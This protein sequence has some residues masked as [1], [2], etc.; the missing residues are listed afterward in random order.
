M[1]SLEIEIPT[2]AIGMLPIDHEQERIRDFSQALKRLQVIRPAEID[3]DFTDERPVP[4]AIKRFLAFEH[5]DTLT[6]YTNPDVLEVPVDRVRFSPR[7]SRVGKQSRHGVFFGDLQLGPG[8]QVPVA[9]KPHLD[10]ERDSCLDEYFNT[11][12]ITQLGMST[13]VELGFIYGD[14]EEDPAYSITVLQEGLSTLDSVDWSS[15]YPDIEEHPGML[16]LWKGAAYQAAKLHAPGNR[17]H[18]DLAG[19]NVGEKGGALSDQTR[20]ILLDWESATI[21][22][23]PPRDAEVRYSHSHSDITTIVESM[24]R[25]TDVDFRAGIGVFA[26]K[27]G[28]WWQGFRAVFLD[29][30]L[31]RRRQIL[32]QTAADAATVRDV[33]EELAELEKSLQQDV[34][35]YQD[36]ALVS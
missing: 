5:E 36:L 31:E 6:F 16:A 29:S 24:C 3:T 14:R 9:V 15:F 33:N 27:S 22:G 23:Q 28:D 30:Y 34:A 12:A 7:I 13:L 19:R 1:S 10:E 8:L 2:E 25:S 21:G 11:L 26:G 32:D 4:F 17:S 18:G 20:V 35:M